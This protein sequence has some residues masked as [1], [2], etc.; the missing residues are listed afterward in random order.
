MA[1]VSKAF[2]PLPR[3]SDQSDVELGEARQVN[4]LRFGKYDFALKSSSQMARPELTR[5]NSLLAF[6]IHRTCLGDGACLLCVFVAT[7]VCAPA[8]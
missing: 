6:S 8:L 4:M 2:T 7:F 5:V 1:A 3:K